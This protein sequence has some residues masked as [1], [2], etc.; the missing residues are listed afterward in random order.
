MTMIIDGSAGVTFPNSTIQASAGSVLQ[1]VNATYA[2]QVSSTSTSFVTTG[3]TATITPKFATSKIYVICN[4]SAANGSNTN[5]SGFTVFRGTVSGTNLGDA[6][7]GII[8]IYNGTSQV[9]AGVSISLL[10][11]PA[12]TSSTT[13]TLA[14][15]TGAGSTAYAQQDNRPASMTLMEI[16]G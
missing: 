16:A 1:V 3:L 10:D 15:N 2:V 12:T 7:A 13:Y 8:Q 14:M 4:T 6:T 5:A 9:R 11:S